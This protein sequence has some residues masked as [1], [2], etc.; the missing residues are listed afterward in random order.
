MLKIENMH[1]GYKDVPVLREV[2]LF[3]GE[4]EI[5]GVVGSNGAGKTTLLKTIMGLIHP[6]AGKIEFRGEDI[7]S[8]GTH[9]ISDLGLGLVFEGRRLFTGMTIVENLMVGGGT[10]RTKPYR[11]DKMAEVF[12]LFPILKERR[13]QL[14]GSLSGG[15]Q[16]MLAIARSLMGCPKLLMIDEVSLG[17]APRVV[18]SI[19]E[20]LNVIKKADMT[21]I[22]VEQNINLCLNF[23]DRAYVME[24][25]RIVAEGGGKELLQDRGIRDKYMGIKPLSDAERGA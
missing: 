5:I 13:K 19:Y 12:D 9:Q 16:Q 3:A 23:A 4:N 14:A 20:M 2:S 25:G 24:N 10:K 1:S 6:T 8:L 21:L 15:E 22:V 7:A 18:E 17:L 11:R